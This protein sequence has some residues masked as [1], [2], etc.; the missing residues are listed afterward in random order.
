MKY[1]ELLLE[2][3]KLKDKCLKDTVKV[4]SFGGV[5]I[6]QDTDFS[7]FS[8]NELLLNHTCLH[9]SFSKRNKIKNSENIV[10]N[11]HERLVTELEKR[12]QKHVFFDKL[13]AKIDKV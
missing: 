12:G 10:R 5:K 11:I 6:R 1:K 7:S 8:N 9:T 13:D 4:I 3:R 2:Q